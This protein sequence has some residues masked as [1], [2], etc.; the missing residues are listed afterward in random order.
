MPGKF[1]YWHCLKKPMTCFT[2]SARR[3]LALWLLH[4]VKMIM[5][6]L[7]AFNQFSPCKKLNF[8]PVTVVNQIASNE[9]K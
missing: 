5:A 3:A 6:A 8:H 4:Q 1:N 9:H 2:L 7:K